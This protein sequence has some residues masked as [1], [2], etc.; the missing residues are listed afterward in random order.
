MKRRGFLFFVSFS[1]L[2]SVAGCT[3]EESVVYCLFTSD[4][5]PS[6]YCLIDGTLF[7]EN[8]GIIGAC[9]AAEPCIGGACPAGYE[10]VD[11]YC[12]PSTNQPQDYDAVYD[13]YTP[14]LD[15]YLPPT[16]DYLPPTD[17]SSVPV[18]EGWHPTD[19]ETPV[20]DD[21]PLVSD[22]S[23]PVAD[24]DEPLTDDETSISD[25]S[26]VSD[27]DSV[28][29]DTDTTPPAFTAAFTS[30]GDGARTNVVRP[31][32]VITFSHPVDETTLVTGGGCSDPEYVITI[33][34]TVTINTSSSA[35][36]PDGK[37]LTIKLSQD[38]ADGTTY[39][40]TVPNTI[41]S[42]GGL[43]LSQTYYWTLIA[44]RTKPTALL[45]TPN[46]TTNV[47]VGSPLVITFSEAMDTASVT[48]GG[49]LTIVG[50]G[51]A[52]AVTGTPVWSAD[53]TVLTL[54]PDSLLETDTTY[55]V[56]L[57]T[58]VTDLAGN[59]L[60]MS[61]FTF[62]TTDTIPP[63]VVST[64]PADGT[65]P[66]PVTL[67]AITVTFSERVMQVN[68]TTFTVKKNDDGTPVIGTVLLATDGLTASFTP[69]A[70]FA[71]NTAYTVMLN[72]EGI[73]PVI[74]DLAGNPLV[75]NSGSSYVF[76]F[77]TG[78]S[79]CNDGYKTGAEACDDGNNDEGDYC[80]GDC[81]AATQPPNKVVV[82]AV[83]D[84]NTNGWYP[85]TSICP[86]YTDVSGKKC[87]PSNYAEVTFNYTINARK[88]Y[89]FFDSDSSVVKNGF[90]LFRDGE[91]LIKYPASGTYPNNAEMLWILDANNPIGAVT[92]RILPDGIE[93][94]SSCSAD[95]VRISACPNFTHSQIPASCTLE[96]RYQGTTLPPPAVYPTNHLMTRFISDAA[97]VYDGF[98][99]T[100]NGVP[101][102]TTPF[103]NYT[104][105][106]DQYLNIVTDKPPT[107][108]I[109]QAFETEMGGYGSTDYTG[110]YLYIFSCPLVQ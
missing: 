73:T 87:S 52:P 38:L 70:P 37:T 35:L 47:P 83:G 12:K 60:N 64:D 78:A 3:I 44:D 62:T 67:K 96:A 101:Y 107:T 22:D 85:D 48:L 45:T 34:P 110:D 30:P 65:N 40:I 49:S 7:D 5:L 17:D 55:T 97:T 23:E 27:T 26:V 66:A 21:A 36:S 50:S 24:E 18:D 75:G 84:I 61:V 58:A 53:D 39:T 57:T 59:T 104:N 100:A 71:D 86:G 79:I 43:L 98:K 14:P 76:T 74:A 72:P 94:A 103:N 89:V 68:E 13:D 108:V 32:L 4:C 91:V 92:L 31:D 93:Y 19:D 42:T 88:A 51:G 54:Q 102:Q 82:T 95:F 80:A 56:T 6:E 105:N 9:V 90:E 46:P 15:D 29:P 2:L 33:T 69:V 99:L 1:L 8:G 11:D 109:F 106:M 41:K 25:D 28:I 63:A 10:C 16:D 20:T 77:T 81:S